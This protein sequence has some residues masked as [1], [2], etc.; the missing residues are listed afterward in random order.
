[1]FN[2]DD[3]AGH[4]TL[5]CKE[6]QVGEVAPQLYEFRDCPLFFGGPVGEGVQ[7]LHRVGGIR[8][9]RQVR[10]A[11]SHLTPLP[12]QLFPTNSTALRSRL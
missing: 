7:V 11:F 6:L 8:G 9:S 12:S 2:D 4:K 1:M 10:F 5:I 3:H